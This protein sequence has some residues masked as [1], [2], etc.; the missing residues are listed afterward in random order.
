MG[1]MKGNPTVKVVESTKPVKVYKSHPIIDPTIVSKIQDHLDSSSLYEVEVG[2]GTFRR[3]DGS[4]MPG[5]LSPVQFADIMNRL[6]EIAVP[7]MYNDKTESME[8]LHARKITDHAT[9]NIIWQKK[10]RPREANIDNDVWG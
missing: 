10:F 5:V 6:K 1:Q 2:F 7:V 4:F 8:K 3:P 9:G